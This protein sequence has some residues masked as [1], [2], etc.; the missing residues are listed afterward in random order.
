MIQTATLNGR[1][2]SILLDEPQD[3]ASFRAVLS[4]PVDVDGGV[5][6]RES[7]T[8]K[9]TRWRSKLE[10]DV[11]L[12][13]AAANALRNLHQTLGNGLVAVPFWTLE[14]ATGSVGPI[15]SGCWLELNA[16]RSFSRATVG[17]PSGGTTGQPVIPL[18]LGRLDR[19]QEPDL[20]TDEDALVKIRFTEDAGDSWVM[21]IDGS[22]PAGPTVA[23]QTVN[24]FPFRPDWATTPAS[25]SAE[26]VVDRRSMGHLR[27]QPSA[28]W[29]QT[30][31]RRVELG[32]TFETPAEWMK[33]L[34]FLEALNG[35]AKTCWL[36]AALSDARLTADVAAAD[37][38][39]ALDDITRLGT[40]EW[41]ALD[42]LEQLVIVRR[43]GT[44]NPLP[45]SSAVGADFAKRH[46]RVESVILARL[47]QDAVT[48]AWQSPDVAT[49]KLQWV[50]ASDAEYSG[51]ETIGTK[52]GALPVS[53]KV[54]EFTQLTPGT[55]PVL[56]YTDHEFP[57]RNTSDSTVYACAPLSHG[58]IRD[59]LNLERNTVTVS[60]RHFAG[61]PLA[62]FVPFTQEW[63]WQLVIREVQVTP[64]GSPTGEFTFSNVVATVLFRGELGPVTTDGPFLKSD[65]EALP[66]VLN[67]K[68]PRRVFQRR[69]NFAVYDADCGAD[70]AA[71]TTAALVVGAV[72]GANTVVLQSAGTAWTGSTFP[73]GRFAGGL[74]IVGSGASQILR[75]V[76][77]STVPD[78]S[79]HMALTLATPVTLA[80][81][82]A[83]SIRPGCDG[84][85]AT[86]TGVFNRKH[87]GFPNMPVGNPSMIKVSTAVGGAKK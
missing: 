19:G 78:G 54:F 70:P 51:A 1:S 47:A 75:F 52:V 8:P 20:E 74:L 40:N 56:R 44:A 2:V 33:A 61:S 38:T 86:C 87:G 69:C 45:L 46:T 5:T 39:L 41:F 77:A 80:N 9:A 22:F 84:T 27:E 67:R 85:L 13:G 24:R 36:P 32:Y 81:A 43:S 63:K 66:G 72:T 12:E 26:I 17:F 50:E 58:D 64:P 79:G 6:N 42:D 29:T 23:G 76:I 14:Q 11:W 57:L 16:D 71:F 48:I 73:V 3:I 82:A 7:R 60:A 35:K 83:V 55:R 59:S 62:Q 37:T 18:L 34:S 68:V 25:G 21:F 49:A 53:A 4:L 28:Y 31:R 15:A 30:S 65:C 10:F